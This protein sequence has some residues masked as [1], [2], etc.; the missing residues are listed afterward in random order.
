MGAFL[1]AQS[2]LP[3]SYAAVGA[4]RGELPPSYVIDHN[5]VALGKG[6][7]TFE[8]AKLALARWEMF[9]LGWLQ[10]CW[11]DAPLTVGTTVGVLVPL[12]GFWLLNACRIVYVIDEQQAALARFGFAYGTLPG[13]LEAGEER[14]LVE[15]NRTDD[16]VWYDILAFSRPH[17]WLARVG[18]PVA[19]LFQKRFARDSKHAMRKIYDATKVN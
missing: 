1:Q 11:P 8:R 13:H 4:T 9:E 19:R 15:W 10:L 12:L 14:F 5:R 18:Y 3:F 16:T 6:Q 2:P 17:H 7:A